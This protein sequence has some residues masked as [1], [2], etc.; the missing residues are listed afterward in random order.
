MKNSLL[1]LTLFFFSQQ[2]HNLDAMHHYGVGCQ[3]DH[4][5]NDSVSLRIDIERHAEK[6][7]QTIEEWFTPELARALVQ[8]SNN[9]QDPYAVTLNKEALDELTLGQQIVLSTWASNPIYWV[10][11]LY[12]F[13]VGHLFLDD[14]WII[15]TYSYQPCMDV[16]IE[17]NFGKEV[18]KKI[19]IIQTKNFSSMIRIK[20]FIPQL[21]HLRYLSFRLSNIELKEAVKKYED[22]IQDLFFILQHPY[23][24]LA[25]IE[26]CIQQGENEIIT[27]FLDYG[28][29]PNSPILS[30]FHDGSDTLLVWAVACGNYD[31][32]SLLLKMHANPLFTNSF[33]FSPWK[34]SLK[35]ISDKK[36]DVSA[37]D[38][39][40]QKIYKLLLDALPLREARVYE[41]GLQAAE[42]N[43]VL[44][45]YLFDK[46]DL[47]KEYQQFLA[48]SEI[49]T[50]SSHFFTNIIY[51]LKDLEPENSDLV[52]VLAGRTRLVLL[53]LLF[54]NLIEG[55]DCKISHDQR[56][57]DMLITFA[58][59]LQAAYAKHLDYFMMNNRIDCPTSLFIQE[60][61]KAIVDMSM[62]LFENKN[63]NKK[64]SLV[65]LINYL[66]NK[67]E[68]AELHV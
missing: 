1:V 40:D 7:A 18:L 26:H 41:A 56:D 32:V 66:M 35:K 60:I 57:I 11:A 31:M 29:D 14:G 24:Y 10:K 53:G 55:E 67:F 13:K 30:I 19:Q 63:F 8:P 39:D 44:E 12:R 3:P 36:G 15:P 68:A 47:F 51:L 49:I 46:S 22:D 2:S 21:E 64:R 52:E 5:I 37:L 20:E 6:A 28:F 45:K 34:I 59:S 58:R 38:Q 50:Q 27:L 4:H 33:H 23:F 62:A 9:P 65:E 54:L 48:V 61:C 16:L 42:I 43:K 25:F 17:F